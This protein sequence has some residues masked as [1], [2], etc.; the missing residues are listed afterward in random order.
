M[1]KKVDSIHRGKPRTLEVAGKQIQTSI[2]KE[3]VLSTIRVGKSGLIGDTQSDQ[4]NH[5]GLDKAICVYPYEHYPFWEK[6]LGKGL[7]V[8]GFGE[9]FTLVGLQEDKVRIGDVYQIGDVIVQVSQ[10]RQPC[11]KLGLKHNQ[12]KLVVWVQETGFSGYYFRVLK[13]GVV[14]PG[15]TVLCIEQ[16]LENP[17]VMEANQVKYA[18]NPSRDKLLWMTNVGELS[19]GWRKDFLKILENK[20]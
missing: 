20:G 14:T 4:V 19:E 5:G 16:K 17:T 1:E 15:D 11:F 18:K 2:F 7:G 10:P 9:N 3:K 6:K 12:P 8:S 13:E